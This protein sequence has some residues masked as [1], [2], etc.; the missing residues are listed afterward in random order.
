MKGF[1][2]T[3]IALVDEMVASLFDE[4]QPRPTDRLLD[5]GCGEGQF[6]DGVLRYCAARGIN[7]P[8]IVGVELEPQRARNARVRF[9][10]DKSV[11]IVTG[12]FLAETYGSFDF[13]VGNPPYVSILG[14]DP[15]ERAS[16]RE[17]FN[18]AR[19]R[20]DLYA[21]FFEHSLR[22]LAPGGRLVFVTPEKFTYVEGA[23]PLRALLLQHGVRALQFV[24]EDVF[25]GRVAYPL[26]TTVGPMTEC[27]ETRIVMRDGRVSTA[28]LLDARSWRGAIDGYQGI[29]S[30]LTLG[31]VTRRISCGVATGADSVFVREAATLPAA[32]HAFAYKTISGRQIGAGGRFAVESVMLAPYD[33]RGV[34]LSEARL[35]GLRD[36]LASRSVRTALAQRSCAKRKPWY[37]FH[38]SFPVADLLRPKILCKDISERP[39][40]V[41]DGTGEIVPR[42]SVYY[43]VPNEPDH[44]FPL[45]DYLNSTAAT[46]WLMANCQRAANGFVRVQS[47]VLKRLPVP[48]G[49]LPSHGDVSV[50][51]EGYELALA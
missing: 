42:H 36:Y 35:G 28:R 13:V 5:P 33:E 19:G 46:D 22:Q 38:D 47:H 25:P 16:Y 15:E 12:D 49:L 27:A 31:D 1:V 43:I 26:V 48:A 32:L 20:F 21:L 9:R 41:A 8:A 2:P 50:K 37:A 14:L 11:T 10:D 24:R 6:I 30:R 7:T 29:Q 17:R 34:L 51:S 3:P 23:A 40:F 18:V 44:L 45:L 39:V 4:R